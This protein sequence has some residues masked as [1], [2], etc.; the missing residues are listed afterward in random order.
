MTV[1]ET[2]SR[3]KSGWSDSDDCTND[4]I[5]SS[6]GVGGVFFGQEVRFC[7]GGIRCSDTHGSVLGVISFVF[8]PGFKQ[9]RNQTQGDNFQKVGFVQR[10]ENIQRD[11]CQI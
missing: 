4:A 8:V 10:S 2:V 7:W 5:A 11:G 6:N 1:H 3:V 9:P